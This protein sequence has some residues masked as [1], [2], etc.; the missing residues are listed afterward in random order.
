[1]PAA[2]ACAGLP[3]YVASWD[4]LIGHCG[5]EDAHAPSWSDPAGF[6]LRSNQLS[7]LCMELPC[8]EAVYLSAPE[9]G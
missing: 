7:Q 6:F 8:P 5:I 1:M 9:I 2:V 4:H 3:A